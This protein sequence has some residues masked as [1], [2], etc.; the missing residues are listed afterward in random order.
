[1]KLECVPGILEVGREYARHSITGHHSHTHSHTYWHGFERYGET[2]EPRIIP[3]K[4]PT[5]LMTRGK[6]TR[7][8]RTKDVFGINSM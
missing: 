2:R 7:A 6:E 8:G 1:M 3:Q 4:V 5:A